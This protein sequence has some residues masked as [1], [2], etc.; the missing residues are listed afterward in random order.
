MIDFWFLSETQQRHEDLRSISRP[1]AGEAF[2]SGWWVSQDR[3]QLRAGAVEFLGFSR[4][5]NFQTT[6]GSSEVVSDRWSSGVKQLAVTLNALK[7]KV[8][9]PRRKF[10]GAL[11]I[12]HVPASLEFQRLGVWDGS[13]NSSRNGTQERMA[14]VTAYD[15]ARH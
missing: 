7:R 12:S 8:A 10:F 4:P 3:H 6:Q 13:R 9:N 14:L 2:V 1:R 11:C 5:S 15:E